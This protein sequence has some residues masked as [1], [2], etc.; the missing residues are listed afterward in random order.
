MQNVSVREKVIM[1]V[2]IA[3]RHY[4]SVMGARADPRGA[5][6]PVTMKPKRPR[7]PNALAKMIVPLTTRTTTEVGDRRVRP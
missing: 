2:V 3:G 5:G 7:F 1:R 6:A 4:G